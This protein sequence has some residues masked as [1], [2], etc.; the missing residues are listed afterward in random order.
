MAA[1]GIAFGIA[2]TL[3]GMFVLEAVEGGFLAEGFFLVVLFW[4]LLFVLVAKLVAKLNR[5]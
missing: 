5:K 2:S 4:V 3:T 1:W